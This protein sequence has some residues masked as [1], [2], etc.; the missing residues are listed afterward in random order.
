MTSAPSTVALEINAIQINYMS[1]VI[2][3]SNESTL[4]PKVV[5]SIPSETWTN[6]HTCVALSVA[7]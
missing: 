6:F 3:P 7:S 4:I 2:G 1:S 5:D